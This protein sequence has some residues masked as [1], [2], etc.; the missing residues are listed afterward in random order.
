MKTIFLIIATI[1]SLLTLASCGGGDKLLTNG[2][3]QTKS[4]IKGEKRVVEKLDENKYKP[5]ASG[6]LR[7][8]GWFKSARG[9]WWGE[10][11]PIK[12]PLELKSGVKDPIL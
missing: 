7:F 12:F 3:V 4:V 8:E 6:D 11:N 1:S 5:Q 10:Q 2:G 9:R